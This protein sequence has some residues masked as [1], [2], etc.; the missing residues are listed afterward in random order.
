MI[1]GLL[2][3]MYFQQSI[4]R[5]LDRDI[6][7][8]QANPYLG[9]YFFIYLFPRAEEK[10]YVFP[11]CIGCISNDWSDNGEAQEFNNCIRQSCKTK[12]LKY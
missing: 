3:F 7:V 2:C 9:I 10:I 5:P 4:M 1:H 8:P 6:F 12:L 11:D